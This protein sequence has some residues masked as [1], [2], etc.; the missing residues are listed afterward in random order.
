MFVYL[1]FGSPFRLVNYFDLEIVRSLS[2][3]YGKTRS[4]IGKRRFVKDFSKIVRPIV[5]LTRKGKRFVWASTCEEAFDKLKSALIGVDVMGYPRNAGLYSLDVDASNLGLGGILSQEQEG[6][7]RVIA[8]GSRA[9]NRTERNYC[10]TQK[11]LLAIRYFVEYYRQYLLGR[12]F[13][14]RS[15][16]QALFFSL[17][18]L[19]H[20]AE[21]LDGLKFCQRTTSSLNIEEEVNNHMLTS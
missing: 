14:V 6:R 12:R 16:H 2:A 9:L 1:F 3:Y 4:E 19:N 10:V 5:E 13:R 7:E 20:V 21:W 17:K 15:N 11:E 8:Y 18:F